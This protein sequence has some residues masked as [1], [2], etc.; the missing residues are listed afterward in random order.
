MFEGDVPTH[1]PIFEKTTPR[2]SLRRVI[3]RYNVIKLGCQKPTKLGDGK[4]STHTNWD[5]FGLRHRG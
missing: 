3:M 1:H 2:I 5:D 4:H